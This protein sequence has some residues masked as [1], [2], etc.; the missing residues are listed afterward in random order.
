MFAF[1]RPKV[2]LFGDSLTQ[3]SFIEGGWGAVLANHYQRKADVLNYGFSGYTTRT[4]LAMFPKLFKTDTPDAER[5]L[6][7]T[8]FLGAN[9]GAEN[10][11]QGVPLAE[12]EANMEELGRRMLTSVCQ[13]LIIVA[14]PPVEQ[15]DW[16]DRSNERAARYAAAAG[17]VA[18]KLGAAFVDTMSLFM[19]WKPGSTD[20]S[21]SAS[22]A[23]G[24]SASAGSDDEGHWKQLLFDGLH[25]GG[26]AGGRLLAGAILAAVRCAKDVDAV[27]PLSKPGCAPEHLPLDFPTWD[28]AL[29]VPDPLPEGCA[30]VQEAIGRNFEE[31]ALAA[32]RAKPT[33]VPGA[34]ECARRTVEDTTARRKLHESFVKEGGLAELDGGA[35]GAAGGASSGSGASS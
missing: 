24:G 6:V 23:P 4:A 9:D 26:G 10:K 17:R 34:T 12:F 7:A 30:S 27:T 5:A 11:L 13:N 29:T 21:G 35:G 31:E 3:M 1:N 19:S 8:L 16:A 32:L 22:A 14:P 18:A 28:A 20:G 15:E 33:G 25:L 2:V